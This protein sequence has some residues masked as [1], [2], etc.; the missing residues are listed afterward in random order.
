MTKPQL[1]CFTERHHKWQFWYA[2][3]STGVRCSAFKQM[4]SKGI[5][6]CPDNPNWIDSWSRLLFS[7]QW[8]ANCTNTI[9]VTD[10]VT[11]VGDRNKHSLSHL[12]S[13]PNDILASAF[14]LASVNF[15]LEWVESLRTSYSW[16][17]SSSRGMLVTEF[18]YSKEV[19]L[20]FCRRQFAPIP[21]VT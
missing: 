8:M 18:V 17:H 11:S 21:A 5:G 6:P 14:H 13:W 1:L 3:C 9:E 20:F 15:A 7:S 2:V 16:V 10:A 4:N 19:C 12:C